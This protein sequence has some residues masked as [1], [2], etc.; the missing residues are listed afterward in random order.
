MASEIQKTELNLKQDKFCRLYATEAEFFGNGVE[1]YI[2]AY[3]PD[4]SKPNA[5]KT[6]ASAASRLLKNVKVIDRINGLLADMGY[7]DEAIDKQLAFLITQH[8]DFSAKLGAIR[9]YNKLKGRINDKPNIN[10][11]MPTPILGGSS[12]KQVEA[13]EVIE[14]ESTDD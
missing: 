13:E 3:E 10:I 6:C 12:R 1:S 14:N 9:E 4:M 7:T 8:A 11:V 5:Y 2:E